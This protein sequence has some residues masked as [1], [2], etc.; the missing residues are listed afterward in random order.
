MWLV[1]AFLTTIFYVGLDYFIKKTAGKIDDFLAAVIINVFAVLP[2]LFVYIWL[3]ITN[4]EILFSQEG[5]LYSVLAGVS[6][7]IGTITF[8]KL[9]ATGANLSIAS[10]FVRIGIIIGTTLLGV[11][12]LKESFTIRQ[13]AGILLSI[14]GL[15]L[16]IF[17]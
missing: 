4:K 7:G 12:V 13:V 16:L 2:A 17:K 10:P 1:Y 14:S 6:I 5:L 9:F 15:L 11:F 3:R 8:I